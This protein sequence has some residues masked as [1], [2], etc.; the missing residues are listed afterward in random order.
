[1]RYTN[2]SIKINNILNRV[3]KEIDSNRNIKKNISILENLLGQP[4]FKPRIKY[5]LFKAYRQDVQIDKAY[6][7]IK[8]L[9]EMNKEEKALVSL[10]RILLDMGEVEVAKKYVN[11]AD[12]SNEKIYLMGLIS[13]YEGDYENAIKILNKLNRTVMEDDMHIEL[14]CVYEYMKDYQSAKEQFNC[15]LKTE[16]RCQAQLRLIKI[17]FAQNDPNLLNLIQNFDIDKCEFKSDMNQYKRCVKY[18]KYLSGDLQKKDLN[19]YSDWQLFSYDKNRAINHIGKYHLVTGKYY[20]FSNDINLEEVYDYCKN[21][22]K[23]LIRKDDTETYLVSMP[24]EVGY[25][26]DHKTNLVEVIV[27]PTTNKIL[28]MYPVAKVGM[29]EKLLNSG[30]GQK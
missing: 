16:R 9:Y 26:M 18:Y 22:L 28:T 4:Y 24:Y 27:I 19:S 29:Y 1:M 10:V 15:L 5:L 12:Y 23:Y 20:K 25:L 30:M 11:Q 21:N 2:G 14:G 17:A 13:E 6:K 7:I 8:D 3:S